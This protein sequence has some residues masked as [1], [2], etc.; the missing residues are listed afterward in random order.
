[1]NRNVAI[2]VDN[3]GKRYGLGNGLAQYST[4]RDYISAGFGSLLTRNS[5]DKP[6]NDFWALKGVSFEVGVGES[7]GVIGLNGAGKSTL[8]KILSR[9]TVPTTGKASIRGRL[10]ALLEVGTG[11]QWELTGRENIYLYGSILGMSKT[12]ITR[13]FQAIVEFSGI[14]EF[15]DTPVKRYSSGMY[16]RL[17]FSVAAHLE[18]EILLLDEV[19]SVGD[20]G[21]Q[22]KC[23]GF[24]QRLQRSDATLLFV[25][26]NMFSIKAMCKRVIYLR[27]GRIK[28][29]GPTD[30][31]IA[32]YEK[33]CRLSHLSSRQD[34]QKNYRLRIHEF[35]TLDTHGH[36]KTVFEYGERMKLRL[37]YETHGYLE[38]PNFILA[39]VRSDGVACCN[40]NTE[41]DGIELGRIHG[42]GVIEL[43]TPPL[44][45]VAE[46]Y[47]IHVIVREPN[48][49][50]LLCEQIGSTFHIKHQLLNTHFG[51]FHEPAD[52]NVM[53]AGW[54]TIRAGHY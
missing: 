44:K 23:M 29:D 42:R 6:R 4:F 16:V 7:V 43:N 22:R 45:L 52:W 20:I 3:V 31:G 46:M 34:Q 21:F 10:G 38:N 5:K 12:E 35:A 48:F 40:Y 8:L 53:E 1:M 26:H 25:S 54:N 24:A 36:Q 17:A 32:L 39:I 14:S 18:P 49:Q 28:Y 41:M 2:S 19:L 30:H 37:V 47:T 15:I 51:V 50:G 27:E 33:D 9:V 13:K 11:F